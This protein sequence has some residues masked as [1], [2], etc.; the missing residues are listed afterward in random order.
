MPEIAVSH[1]HF[2]VQQ[3][4]QESFSAFGKVIEFSSH[5][6]DER[7]EVVLYEEKEPWRIAVFRV[8]QRTTTRLE[9]HPTSM[10]SFEPMHGTGILLVAAP[11]TPCQQ[12]A[13]LLDKPICLYKGVW[14]EVITLSE[15]SIYKIT[16]NKD[17]SSEFYPL[18]QPIGLAAIKTVDKII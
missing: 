3:L 11:Q 10:E 8:K 17:V 2:S 5:P 16:E 9:C 4:T 13:F 6:Q 12:Y 14:H 18:P 15:E 7:F 1:G